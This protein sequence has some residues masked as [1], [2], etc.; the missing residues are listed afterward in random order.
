ML[1]GEFTA[2]CHFFNFPGGAR[3]ELSIVLVP[4]ATPPPKYTPTSLFCIVFSIYCIV[5]TETS[6]KCLSTVEGKGNVW[7][8]NNLSS[9]FYH[10]DG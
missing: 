7:L 10:G 3:W 5:Y 9:S 1:Q 8:M 2:I 4:T 6:L